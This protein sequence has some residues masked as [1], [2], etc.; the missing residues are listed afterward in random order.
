MTAAKSNQTPLNFFL[1]G[2]ILFCVGLLLYFWSQTYFI[3][4]NGAHQ[5]R[6]ADTLTTAYF[7][8]TNES[9]FFKPEIAAREGT[10]GVAIG[11]FPVYSYIV[12]QTCQ[13]LGYWSE[14]T[15]KVINWL[16]WILA[17]FVWWNFLKLRLQSKALTDFLIWILLFAISPTLVN[18]LTI[19][20]PEATALFFWGTAA[21]FF[22]KYKFV[23]QKKWATFAL[24]FFSIGFLIRPYYIPF[25]FFFGIPRIFKFRILLLAVVLFVAWYKLWASYATTMP[26][27]FGI[28]FESLSSVLMSIPSALSVMPTRLMDHFT[29]AG[30]I[31]ALYF[32]SEAKFLWLLYFFSLL[33][34]LALKATHLEAHPYYLLASAVLA[35]LILMKIL[36]ARKASTIRWVLSLYVLQSFASNIHNFRPN[37]LWPKIKEHLIEKQIPADSTIASYLG[38]NPAWHYFLKRKGILLQ[39]GSP[40]EACLGYDFSLKRDLENNFLIEPCETF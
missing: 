2:I 29:L 3:P 11:E 13:I 17:I 16:F 20:L 35:T 30:L 1:S 28:N 32:W 40:A 10:T 31:L 5:W 21:W 33:I 34:M 18:Y 37:H 23:H 8:C 39:E 4:L 7:Y 15:P 22:E 27:Y 38:K 19:T 6:Q 12:G 24:V 14:V 9:S 26:M 25:L 36:R